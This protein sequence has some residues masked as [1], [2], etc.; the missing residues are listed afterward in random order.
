MANVN[1]LKDAS[2]IGTNIQFKRKTSDADL[3]TID[4]AP[5]EPLFIPE[6]NQLRI[7]KVGDNASDNSSTILGPASLAANSTDDGAE[8]VFTNSDQ[9]TNTINFKGTNGVSVTF[10]EEGNITLDSDYD[11][12]IDTPQ[13]PNNAVTLNLSGKYGDDATKSSVTFVGS[14]NL[15]ITEDSGKIKLNGQY[16][17]DETDGEIQL[18]VAVGEVTGISFAKGTEQGQI[19]VGDTNINIKDLQTG[20]SPTFASATIGGITLNS[21]GYHGNADSATRVD[22]TNNDDGNNAVVKFQVG[23]GQA[24]EKTI[25]NVNHATSADKWST[26]KTIALAGAVTGSA[27]V[28]GSDNVSIST[29]AA[30]ATKTSVG[31]MQVGGNLT[32][33]DGVVGV[34]SSPTFSNVILDSESSP[35]LLFQVRGSSI[36]TFASILFDSTNH[37]L[38]T[39]AVFKASSFVATSDARLKE[40]IQPYIPTKNTILELPIYKFDFINNGKKNNIG[41]LAQDLQKICPEIVHEDSDG[42]LSI[43][44]SKIV[45][46]LLGEVK[47]LREELNE[48]KR[49]VRV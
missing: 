7:G 27:S 36:T 43:E 13:T 9:T 14:D 48:L 12:S 26:A 37:T 25:N 17:L 38:K 45:Y 35:S 32:V 34:V 15:S 49:G 20:S 39:S 11:L 8:L 22:I 2:K 29:T 24:Y 46:L 33:D 6:L 42:Y 18:K 23:D 3:S 16:T 31:V 4:L 28:D 10:D 44:E 19:K 21:T 47:Q 5:G 1:E 30:K 41:C 40:N